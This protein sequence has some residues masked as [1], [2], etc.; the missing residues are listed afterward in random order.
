MHVRDHSL[1]EKQS[2]T[3]MCKPCGR[4]VDS[5][6]PFLFGFLGFK[7][8][9]FS[10]KFWTFDDQDSDVQDCMVWKSGRDVGN[11]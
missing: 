9:G 7:N 2:G 1:S 4:T 8:D 11:T 5:K 3:E 10:E 6:I